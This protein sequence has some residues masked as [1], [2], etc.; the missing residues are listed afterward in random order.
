MKNAQRLDDARLAEVLNER[1]M[2]DLDGLREMLQASNDGGMTFCEAVVTAGLVSD[3]DLS[4]VVAEL[5]QLP[6]LP[7]DLC[8]PDPVL[9]EE[10][11]SPLMHEN[12]LVPIRRFG[13]L[14]TVAMPGLVA[15]DVLG[16]LAAETDLFL[17]PVVGTVETNRRWLA[18]NGTRAEQQG[19]DWGSLFDEGDAAVRA[20]LDDEV[21][22][23]VPI[24]AEDLDLGALEFTE[25]DDSLDALSDLDV[26]SPPSLIDTSGALELED[27]EPSPSAPVELP[28]LPE[29]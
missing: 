24:A 27:E 1:G 12:A 2:A 19:G 13:Q 26:L 16:M 17:L 14:L 10:L 28:P 3:W 7:V 6:F 20:S 11:E 5:F 29:F 18:T 23:G 4:R 25:D 8:K 22:T 15:A 9:W 21:D